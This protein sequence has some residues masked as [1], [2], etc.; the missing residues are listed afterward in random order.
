LA[1]GCGGRAATAL[2][3]SDPKQ[4][5]AQ[6]PRAKRSSPTQ[7][8]AQATSERHAK[9]S[10][11][12]SKSAPLKARWSH[13]LGRPRDS[14]SAVGHLLFRALLFQ[15]PAFPAVGLARGPGM[16]PVAIGLSTFDSDL[17]DW[18]VS[19]FSAIRRVGPQLRLRRPSPWGH[20]SARSRWPR[21]GCSRRR[22]RP[23]R[24]VDKRS[25]RHIPGLS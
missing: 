8:A 5:G 17:N 4:P 2:R 18:T 22:T 1:V 10:Q 9:A 20:R 11:S 14:Q 21:E 19:V 6:S 23:L 24:R 12:K 15:A 13:S 25:R 3:R 16:A 7:Q